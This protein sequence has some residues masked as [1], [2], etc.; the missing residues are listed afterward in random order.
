VIS[1]VHSRLGV[2]SIWLVAILFSASVSAQQTANPQATTTPPPPQSPAPPDGSPAATFRSRIDLVLVPVVVRDHKGTHLP[3]LTKDAFRLQ[4]NG[5]DQTISVFEEVHA[6]TAEAKPTLAP[7]RG[8]SNL[9]FDNAHQ[10]RYTILVIDLLNTSLFQRADAKDNLSKFLAKGVTADQPV[11]ILCITSKGLKQVQP[12]GTDPKAL[13]ETLKKLDVGPESIMARNNRVIGAIN[14]IRDIAQAYAGIPGRKTLVFAAGFMPE[15]TSEAA[16]IDTSPYAGDLRRMW[17]ALNNSNIAVY[18]FLL[19]DWSRNNARGAVSRLDLHMRDFAE[20]T[21]GG[22]CVEANDLMNCLASAVEDSRSYYMLGFSVQPNDRKPGWR[23]LKVKVSAEHA[24]VHSRDGFYYGQ[25]STP[26]PPSV[27]DQEINALASA[28]PISAIP[29]FVKVL[30]PAAA[31][32]SDKKKTQFLMT[33]PLAGVT[34]DSTQP[35]P[36]DLEIGAIA[37]TRDTREAAEFLHP[38]RGNPNPEN[39]QAWAREGIMLQTELDLPPGSYD[40]RFFARDNNT[41]QIGTVVFPLDVK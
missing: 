39:L 22:E 8:Y 26:A 6:P 17:A 4:E 13:I 40:I 21:G 20:S 19:M 31:T 2:N 29:M 11:S 33:I 1:R 7:D 10:L 36:L 15:L 12:F 14:Q 34:I 3:G 32:E 35:N 27:H 28:V 16:I 5:K 38:V 24:N 18:T 25:P 9:P 37:L 23:D 30:T 41:G